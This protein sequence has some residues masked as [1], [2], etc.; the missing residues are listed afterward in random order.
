[1]A[2]QTSLRLAKDATSDLVL[3]NTAQRHQ[4]D[5]DMMHDAMRGDVLEALLAAQR[6]DSLLS[7]GTPMPSL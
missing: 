1:M 5:S 4:M 2:G 7:A 6:N 3:N